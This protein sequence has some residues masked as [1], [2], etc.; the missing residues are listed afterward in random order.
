VVTHFQLPDWCHFFSF[1]YFVITT[2]TQ[3][4]PSILGKRHGLDEASHS[5]ASPN[6]GDNAISRTPGFLPSQ[7]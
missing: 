3:Q 1:F 7:E 6:M 5:R 2:Q 4:S